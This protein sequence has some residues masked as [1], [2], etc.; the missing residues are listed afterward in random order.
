MKAHAHPKS[1]LQ[2]PRVLVFLLLSV[3]FIC[4]SLTSQGQDEE[5]RARERTRA[6]NAQ[7]QG[8]LVRDCNDQLTRHEINEPLFCQKWIIKWE[9]P[10]GTMWGE[11]WGNSRESVERQRDQAIES[12]KSIARFF[13]IPFDQNYAN[14]SPPICDECDGKHPKRQLT[15]LERQIVHNA[16][17]AYDGW[18]DKIRDLRNELATEAVL[19]RL[20]H[21]DISLNGTG[22]VLKSYANALIDAEHRLEELREKLSFT[23]KTG[24]GILGDLDNFTNQ[25]NRSLTRVDRLHRALPAAVQNA[26]AGIDT[27]ISTRESVPLPSAPQERVARR[28]TPSSSTAYGREMLQALDNHDLGSMRNLLDN[29]KAAVDTPIQEND[30]G[31]PVSC[32]QAILQHLPYLEEDPGMIDMARLLLEHGASTRFWVGQKPSL[33]YVQGWQEYWS[34]RAKLFYDD[35]NLVNKSNNLA[36]RAQSLVDLLIR[37]QNR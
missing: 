4:H 21:L 5:E 6:F 32:L 12:E 11:L 13:H 10:N 18:V 36:N 24:L 20:T 8:V 31:S 37:Y 22:S 26:I 2:R 34:S 33:E 17:L 27:V 16:T 29:K 23:E 7:K 1:S 14:P 25:L 30:D 3:L 28:P 15:R 35:P 9:K 19:G